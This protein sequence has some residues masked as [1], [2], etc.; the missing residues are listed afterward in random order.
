MLKTAEDIESWVNVVVGKVS[1]KKRGVA[2][3]DAGVIGR[4]KEG[5][6]VQRP[7]LDGSPCCS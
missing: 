7:F 4:I 2:N 3:V 5:T 1:Q 6:R